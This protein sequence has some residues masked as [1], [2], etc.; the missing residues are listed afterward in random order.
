MPPS[1]LERPEPL[2]IAGETPAARDL[3]AEDILRLPTLFANLYIAGAA[4][5]WALVDAGLPG[6]ARSITRRVERR[7]GPGAR[8]EAII[9]THGH[10]DHAGSALELSKQWDVPIL[11]HPLELPYLT[12]KS[13]YAPKDPTVGG[14]ISI[15]AR[16]F[17]T[18]GYDFGGRVLA[19]P[20]GGAVPGLPEW[21]WIHTP[22][23]THGHV[24]LFRER[25]AVLLA[26]DALTTVNQDDLY[27][28][29]MRTPVFYRPPAPF[30]ADWDAAETSIHALAALAP[31]AV[32]AGH[33]WPIQG[34]ATAGHLREFASAFRRPAHGRYV[35]SPALADANGIQA[36]PSPVPDPAGR[37]L[38]LGAAAG[39][40][41]LAGFLLWKN[42]PAR[43]HPGQQE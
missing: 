35:H 6:F 33:G 9:L 32:G 21:R 43:R 28:A 17:P 8:P 10:W 39:L 38:A 15:A 41:A 24:S 27:P 31:R 29:L 5:S 23:H 19:L 2:E 22:G 7:F 37:A 25:D 13:D 30:T 26:G 1:D 4:R 14:F 16:L 11:A 20:A 12:G 34:P 36:L 40:G 18:T 3:L 42:S